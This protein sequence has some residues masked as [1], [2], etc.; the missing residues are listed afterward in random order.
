VRVFKFGNKQIIILIMEILR[1]K[2]GE[3][4]FQITSNT[5]KQ[6]IENNKKIICVEKDIWTIKLIDNNNLCFS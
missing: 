5:T 1:L 2:N 3:Q 6:K 4:F